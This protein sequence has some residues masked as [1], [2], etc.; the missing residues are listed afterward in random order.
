MQFKNLSCSVVLTK[1][2]LVPQMNHYDFKISNLTNIEG[3]YTKLEIKFNLWKCSTSEI[4]FSWQ[5]SK[6]L[7]PKNQIVQR[8][9][10]IPL[11]KLSFHNK[12]IDFQQ[13]LF[14]EMRIEFQNQIVQTQNY[15]KSKVELHNK[16][17]ITFLFKNSHV[18]QQKLF[19]QQE[20]WV[21]QREKIL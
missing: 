3:W 11:K 21:Q 16:W 2:C 20:N 19:L 8:K 18:L 13:R 1:N 5:K 12:N 10:H 17:I 4:H 9:N 14:I 6:A 7:L 15:W